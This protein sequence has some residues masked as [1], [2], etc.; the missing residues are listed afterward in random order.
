MPGAAVVEAEIAGVEHEYSALEGVQEDVIEIL[1]NLKD[2]AIK[3]HSR[4]E[5]VLSL[6]KQ[7]PAVVTAG[8]IALDHS[9]EIVNLTTSLHTSMKVPS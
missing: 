5:A 9:V 3:M 4:D 7:G 6:N 1:L 8:D 2:V